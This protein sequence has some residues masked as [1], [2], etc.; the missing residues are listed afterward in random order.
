MSSLKR[1]ESV[2]KLQE[3][4][5][6]STGALS[7]SQKLLTCLVGSCTCAIFCL[8][9]LMVVAGAALNIAKISMGA[10]YFHDCPAQ[11]LVPIFLIVGG[12]TT[13]VFNCSCR[14]S[15]DESGEMKLACAGCGAVVGLIVGVFTLC[16]LIVGTV[17]VLRTSNE[18]QSCQSTLQT[19]TP[20][21]FNVTSTSTPANPCPICDQTLLSFAY[22]IIITEW[23]IVGVTL[24]VLFCY[25]GA[26]CL[27]SAAL[28]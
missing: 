21:A 20:T 9:L 4:R 11:S 25:C 1:L 5:R 27:G 22:G 19:T 14:P 16:W 23:C 26:L 2:R 13:L 24:L 6:E 15:K 8:I 17:F 12:V 7:F 18:I 10:V 3:M 28:E